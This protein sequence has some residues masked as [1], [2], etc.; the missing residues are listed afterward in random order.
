KCSRSWILPANRCSS[1]VKF[2]EDPVTRP[3]GFRVCWS[4][5]EICGR[6]K[7]PTPEEL[8][9]VRA[10]KL[11]TKWSSEPSSKRNELGVRPSS[12]ERRLKQRPDDDPVT[13]VSYPK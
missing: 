11:S 2:V 1:V 13:G 3:G 12:I 4:F 8:H 6:S 5:G 7:P 9:P 10:F